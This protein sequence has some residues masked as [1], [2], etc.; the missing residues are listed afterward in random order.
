MPSSAAGFVRHVLERL[1]L[2][3]HAIGDRLA[4]VGVAER[5]PAQIL[6]SR[7]LARPC[8]E[9]ADDDTQTVQRCIG[10]IRF[11]VEAHGDRQ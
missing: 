2:R 7:H 3:M 9:H 4:D 11:E 5:S 1:A 6:E 10:T 8:T